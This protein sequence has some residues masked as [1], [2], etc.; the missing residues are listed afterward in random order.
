MVTRGAHDNPDAM[1]SPMQAPVRGEVL[2]NALAM[3]SRKPSAGILAI[4]PMISPIIR[5]QNKPIAIWLIPSTMYL[6]K[7][8]FIYP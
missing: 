1:A 7:N 8:F 4:W 2:A 5:E 6:L 3:K